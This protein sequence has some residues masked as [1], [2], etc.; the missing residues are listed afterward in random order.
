M[1]RR[2]KRDRKDLDSPTPPPFQPIPFAGLF[3]FCLWIGIS[4]SL[5]P[6]RLL[7]QELAGQW[8][9][10]ERG[11][12]RHCAVAGDLVYLVS[13]ELVLVDIS[14][15][16]NPERL[17]SI[18]LDGTLSSVVVSGGYAYVG[19]S[20]GMHIVDVTDPVNPQLLSAFACDSFP[21]FVLTG[22]H[23]YTAGNNLQ[24]ID[25]KD[26]GS[27]VLIHSSA[28]GE[29]A[30]DV[31][32]LQDSLVAVF[33]KGSDPQTNF[34]LYDISNPAGPTLQ[35]E[36][37]E[38]GYVGA[39]SGAQVAV[40]GN[41]LFVA[42]GNNLFIFS[43]AP[44]GNPE[45]ISVYP[46]QSTF[47][48]VEPDGELL[49]LSTHYAGLSIADISNP[50]QPSVFRKVRPT[51]YT[52]TGAYSNG[53]FYAVDLYDGLHV[54]DVSPPES[55]FEAGSLKEI[56]GYAK[57]VELVGTHAFVADGWNG[58]H[59]LDIADPGNI[60]VSDS[61]LVHD[62]TCVEVS[63]N[64]AYVGG[65]RHGGFWIFDIANSSDIR[66]RSSLPGLGT[67]NDMIVQDN[68]AILGT[69][70]CQSWSG[71]RF[72]DVSDSDN[73]ADAGSYETENHV[74]SLA[75]LNGWLLVPNAGELDIVDI[76]NP[77]QPTLLGRSATGLSITEV[78]ASGGIVYCTGDRS[79]DILALD[80]S[81]P[82]HPQ[83]LA[84][85]GRKP[86]L[87][88]MKASGD[89]LYFHSADYSWIT[90]PESSLEIYS[91]E[92]KTTP[93]QLESFTA[94]GMNSSDL[95]NT[96]IAGAAGGSGMVLYENPVAPEGS[97]WDH[98]QMHEDNW[99]RLSWYGWFKE[100]HPS[101]IY[102]MEHG[103]VLAHGDSTGNYFFYDARLGCWAWSSHA[104]YP[105]V[106]LYGPGGGWFWYHRG[107]QPGSRFLQSISSGALYREDG[108]FS[109]DG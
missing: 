95:T 29:Y 4:C 80:T 19:S 108:I 57:D 59:V 77:L 38:S 5:L 100:I 45:L 14:D 49:Y 6:G 20:S 71:V 27:P 93:V 54:I 85:I 3:R 13:T 101:W 68:L 55:A 56:A 64:T 47:F 84:T 36:H 88:S 102:H 72:V 79:P 33:G 66:L 23:V 105:M 75:V 24:V 26:P 21:R 10:F 11:S 28:Y 60:R 76:S 58:F 69:G 12:V 50:A 99:R 30:T 18:H 106:Y 62:A 35:W 7:S 82:R 37:S 98:A 90:N 67:V 32:I 17:S 89:L 44:N 40:Q 25:V 94:V 92:T 87:Q 2:C 97:L 48:D 16:G 43:K 15:P 91:M 81:D 103:H 31:A 1:L 61:Y 39:T 63:G 73:P 70:Y 109:T 83:V 96:H 65:G 107:S 86:I 53:Y 74:Q 51:T 52:I 104:L 34:K 78:C 42:S 9:G 22:G 41:L 46:S 8:P